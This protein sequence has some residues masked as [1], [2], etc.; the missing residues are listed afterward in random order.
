[1][2][3]IYRAPKQQGKYPPLPATVSE[4]EASRPKRA[5]EI[6]AIAGGDHEL[7]DHLVARYF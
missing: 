5:A 7:D 1:V 2:V 3:D 6:E 4:N